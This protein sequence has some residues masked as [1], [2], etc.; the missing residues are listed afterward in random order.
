SKI[1]Q[2]TQAQKD[3][4]LLLKQTTNKVGSARTKIT[5]AGTLGVANKQKKH[6][7]GYAELQQAQEMLKKVRAV[8][9]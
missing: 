5:K 8:F 9:K 6:K 3:A 2:P 4:N 7:E 1:K